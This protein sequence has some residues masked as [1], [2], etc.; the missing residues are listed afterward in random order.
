MRPGIIQN[1]DDSVFISV[2]PFQLLDKIQ[3]SLSA[4][5][6]P[7]DLADNLMGT[8]LQ[9]P[10][11]IE[12]LLATIGLKLLKRA[13]FHVSPAWQGIMHQVH[14]VYEKDDNLAGCFR[15]PL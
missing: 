7:A 11:N 3:E 6:S 13:L 5:V 14:S 15:K 4:T 9:S 12:P 10:D 1:Q 8:A 2:M